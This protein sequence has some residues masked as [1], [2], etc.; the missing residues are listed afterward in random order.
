MRVA[1]TGANRG[2]G[3]ALAQVWRNFGHEVVNFSRTT[4]YD[5]N[6]PEKLV[7]AVKDFD[8]FINNAY[9]YKTGFAQVDLLYRLFQ[10]W[11]GDSKKFIIN[12][13]TEQTNRWIQHKNGSVMSLPWE[14]GQRRFNYRTTKVALEDA[15]QFL[16]QQNDSP[17]MIIVKPAILDTPR[18]GSFVPLHNSQ[19]CKLDPDKV[20]NWL[21]ITWANHEDFFVNEIA[22]RPL[23]WYYP[24][25]DQ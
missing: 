24:E 14:H 10:V 4:G 12:I 9:C 20:A 6:E 21:Y 2:F 8:M 19:R 5:I 16:S 1:I 17:K 15:H 22:V 18:L 3:L 7:E 11:Q 23:E 13:S 25:V